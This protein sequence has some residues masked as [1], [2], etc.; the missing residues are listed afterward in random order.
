M[1]PNFPPMVE[2]QSTRCKNWLVIAPSTPNIYFEWKTRPGKG[3]AHFGYDSFLTPAL[4]VFLD[5]IS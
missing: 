3:K 2:F 5:N 1:F 4:R